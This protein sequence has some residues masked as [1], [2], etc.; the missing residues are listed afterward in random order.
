LKTS[1]VGQDRHNEE[2]MRIDLKDGMEDTGSM[3]QGE[4]W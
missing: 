3:M 2:G 4:E 1:E